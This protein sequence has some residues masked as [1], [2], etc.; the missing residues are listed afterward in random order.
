MVNIPLF[1]RF[2]TSKRWFCIISLCK[3][4]TTV[5]PS[6]E[7]V[8]RVCMQAGQPGGWAT[9]CFEVGWGAGFKQIFRRVSLGLE[10]EIHRNLVWGKWAVS[11]NIY[12]S[13]YRKRDGFFLWDDSRVPTFY[14]KLEETNGGGMMYFRVIAPN[15]VWGDDFRSCCDVAFFLVF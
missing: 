5:I 6:E 15:F 11:T 10:W 9:S 7:K 3:K 4:K 13:S 12:K 8:V 14:K 1:T 2:Y